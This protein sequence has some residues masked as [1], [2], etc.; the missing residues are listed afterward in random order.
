MLTK[1]INFFCPSKFSEKNINTDDFGLDCQKNNT[2][3]FDCKSFIFFSYLKS[4]ELEP[5]IYQIKD[6]DDHS[7][8]YDKNKQ[9]LIVN[10]SYPFSTG[11]GQVSLEMGNLCLP[12]SDKVIILTMHE[13]HRSHNGKFDFYD[14]SCTYLY[15]I[16]T[17]KI[18]KLSPRKHGYTK[19]HNGILI[20]F[21]EIEY[22]FYRIIEFQNELR[23]LKIFTINEKITKCILF[24][25]KFIVFHGEKFYSIYNIS[26]SEISHKDKMKFLCHNEYASDNLKLFRLNNLAN[27]IEWH[28]PSCFFVSKKELC[29]N[30]D[31]I[32]EISSGV[33]I[34]NNKERKWPSCEI[35]ILNDNLDFEYYLDL[36]PKVTNDYY[37]KKMILSP[38]I[39]IDHRDWCI[40]FN[41]G[42]KEQINI[43]IHKYTYHSSEMCVI[44]FPKHYKKNIIKYL[45]AINESISIDVLLNIII[46]YCLISNI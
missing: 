12:F 2:K 30:I 21:E 9:N 4:G 37:E 16:P 20:I 15:H 41:L 33:Y 19:F 34:F 23:I 36:L 40:S 43:D 32:S 39:N 7:I 28:D 18:Y 8:N 1:F 17:N 3:A 10:D 31:Y 13:Y 45:L 26:L 42:T 35:Y 38:E 27:I 24:K 44:P 29:G 6:W 5:I 25:D 11:Y 14:N 22:C 46:D